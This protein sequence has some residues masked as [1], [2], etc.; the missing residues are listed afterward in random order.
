ML[1]I[2]AVSAPYIAS[3]ADV[4]VAAQKASPMLA[5]TSNIEVNLHLFDSWNSAL[6]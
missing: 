3:R 6:L 5:L 2:L 1:G 4:V